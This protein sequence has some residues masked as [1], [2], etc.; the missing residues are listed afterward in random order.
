VFNLLGITR[1][2][3]VGFAVI[4]VAV[5]AGLLSSPRTASADHLCGNTGSPAGPFDILTYE[6]ADWRTTYSKTLELASQNLLF[7]DD[8]RFGLPQLE[9]GPRSAGS[10][11][12]VDP[13]I[14]PTILKA[15]AWIESSWIQADYSVPYGAVGPVL[16]SHDCGY[17]ITQV[18]SGMQNTTG[19]PDLA[20]VMI[21][22]HYGFNI[23]EGARI[24]ATKWN[25]TPNYRPIVGTRQPTI[26]EDWYYAVWSYNGF[27]FGNHPL[28]PAYSLPRGVYRCDGTQSRSGYPYQELV[29][30]CVANPPVVGGAPLW[31][32]QPVS[33]PNLSHPA[34]SLANWNA[35]SGSKQCAGMDIPTP[36]PSHTDS[37][38]ASGDRSQALGTPKLAISGSAFQMVLS[39]ETQ[40]DATTITVSNVGTGPLTWRLSPS[41]SWLKLSR[42]QGVS[43]GTDL[44][45][46]PAS[47]QFSVDTRGLPPG[48]YG[49]KINLQSRYAQG[50]PQSIT[51]DLTVV[52]KAA[53]QM[54]AADVN[55][56][57]KDDIVGVYDYGD[58]LIGMW[59]F[60]SDGTD[61]STVRRSYTG[62]SGCWDLSKSQMV[63]ADV[64]GDG[65][66]D[67]VGIYNYGDGLMRMWSF[68][69]DGT[70][71]SSVYQSYTGCGGCWDLSKS[72]MVAADVNGDGKDDIVGIYNYSG[73]LMRMWNFVSDG[74]N[75]SSMY[76]S[77]AGCGGCWELSQAQMV[78][79]DVNGDGKDDIVGIYDYGGGLM[80]MWNFVSDGAN[81]SSVYRSYVGCGGCWELSQ[82]QM[83][84]ADV[85]GDGKDDI[86]GIYDYGG[87]L[88]RMWNFLS[89]GTD[90]STVRRSYTGCS[91]CWNLQLA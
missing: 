67:I 42:I 57:G 7:S 44:G 8:T 90:F 30:G 52:P 36:T 88:M 59:S 6:A 41:V 70:N 63:A 81:F 76:R 47:F 60:L 72:Q 33:L 53:P 73:G 20:Q 91:G 18:T 64:N 35:C 75:F 50:L 77:Y 83:M 89:D 58:G 34:F 29:F 26:T 56:D 85:N 19:V 43:L 14:P 82:A 71:F 62:C 9:T 79:A 87:G 48:N 37:T 16:V 17:G 80:R 65:K 23:A 2:G 54:L 55:G 27:T 51:V 32:P 21:G 61:F 13:S 4:M 69:S 84:A 3:I 38:P 45:S 86:V 11:T 78:V 39:E 5:A 40:S 24:L 74:A 12:L 10:S 68:I 15:I 1:L 66:D 25:A 31:S 22:G 28:N 49:G 46:A